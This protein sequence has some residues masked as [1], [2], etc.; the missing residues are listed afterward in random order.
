MS[1]YSFG[2][3][4]LSCHAW[5]KNRTQI[6]VSPNSSV[7]I[8]YEKKGN[9]WAKIHELTEH[10]GR[11][12]GID[13]APDSNRI[14]TCASDRNAYVWTL[15]DKVWKPTL[16]LVR[17][18]RAATCVK[19]SPLENKFALGS[20]A[21]LISV[22]YFEKENDWVTQLTTDRL[23]LVSVLYV[24]PTEMVAA[25]HDCCPFQFSYKGP[26]SLKFVKKLD[27]PKQT[28]RGSMS[29]MQHFRNL[30]KKAT[31]DE[32]NE[33]GCLHQNSI[34]QLCMVSGTKTHVDKYSSV[35]LD[36]AMVLWDFK[37]LPTYTTYTKVYGHPVK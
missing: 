11:I 6:A 29:A 17:I 32:S 23:P 20:G 30:D 28:S 8:I 4:P 18:N 15:K 26:G 13:W 37:V 25:G 9:E 14:V 21:R 19:W 2:L 33:L 34:T 27:I 1:L 10:S 35:G 12:T 31:D 5:N 22:C 7:V 3:E 16:V 24:S 36:G